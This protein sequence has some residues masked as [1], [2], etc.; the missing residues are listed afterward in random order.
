MKWKQDDQ[1]VTLDM[2]EDIGNL[3]EMEI[4]RPTNGDVTLGDGAVHMF[5][6][7]L[8]K[9]RWPVSQDVPK[10]AYAV[11]S[12][13]QVSPAVV[14]WEQA[15]QLNLV[16][17]VL[18][19]MAKV[20]QA[21][22][23]LPRLRGDKITVVTPF[24]VSFA[25]EPGVKSQEGFVP[26]LTTDDITRGEVPCA[27]VEVQSTT[28]SRVV[29]ESA[30]LSTALDRQLY[31]RWVA[32]IWVHSEPTCPPE[33]RHKLT[34]PGILVTNAKS[35]Y[36][37]LN[38]TGKIPKERRTMTDLLVARDLIKAN[39]VEWMWLHSKHMRVDILTK[40][41][42]AGDTFKMFREKQAFSLIRN[43]EEQEQEQRRRGLRPGQRL[44]RQARDKAVT[45]KD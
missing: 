45:G 40:M 6:S 25:K 1:G 27:L 37:H 36:D 4:K 22:I 8:A 30:S 24:D 26:F 33:W 38:T 16:A 43:G 9:V 35:L 32:P 20:G 5:K 28:I 7:M 11:S 17:V 39:A 2:G 34:I 42:V 12:L 29:S 21:Q 14:E 31:E 41:M 10:L 3:T 44:R 19:K 13:A 15:R 18:K 23:V